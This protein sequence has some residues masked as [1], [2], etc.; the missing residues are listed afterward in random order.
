VIVFELAFDIQ[1]IVDALKLGATPVRVRG[2]RHF[3]VTREVSRSLDRVDRVSDWM[4]SLLRL[5]DGLLSIEEIVPLLS[6]RLPDVENRLHE[7]VCMRLLKGAQTEKLIAIY[8]T[9]RRTQDSH[10]GAGSASKFC[11]G[12]AA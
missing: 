7:Y 3:Y 5:C 2:G 10:D 6:P 12:H 8:R 4:A 11:A 1:R 9:A